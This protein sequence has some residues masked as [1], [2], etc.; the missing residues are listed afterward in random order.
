MKR[1]RECFGCLDLVDDRDAEVGAGDVGLAVG[2]GHD[3]VA[4]DAVGAGAL[5]GVPGAEPAGRVDEEPVACGIRRLKVLED[6]DRLE[7]LR[8]VLLGEAESRSTTR[9]PPSATRLPPAPPITPTRTFVG[10]VCHELGD[11]GSHTADHVAA[12]GHGR[13]DDVDA[14][15]ARP[16]RPGA[17]SS[18]PSM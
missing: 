4:A 6:A 15:R 9:G 5:A 3:D 10:S 11:A 1:S 12:G 13:H 7:R 2:I 8:L 14:L 18:V 16:T 17:S